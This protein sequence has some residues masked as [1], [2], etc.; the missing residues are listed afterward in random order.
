MLFRLLSVHDA[1]MTTALLL[2]GHHASLHILTSSR[3]EMSRFASRAALGGDQKRRSSEMS[4]RRAGRVVN[5]SIGLVQRA[6][7]R[8]VA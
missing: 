8:C 3:R 7:K 4:R 2:D 1:K 6:S 5:G